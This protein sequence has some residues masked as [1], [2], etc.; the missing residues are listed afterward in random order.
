MN[1]RTLLTLTC[2]ISLAACGA[3]SQTGKPGPLGPRYDASEF[4]R[5]LK[6]DP[7]SMPGEYKKNFLELKRAIEQRKP[8][9]KHTRKVQIKDQDISATI[10]ADWETL[11]VGNKKVI[12]T[13]SLAGIEFADGVSCKPGAFR[14]QD[15]SEPYFQMVSIELNCE[16]FTDHKHQLISR[17]FYWNGAAEVNQPLLANGELNVPG[18]TQLL[19]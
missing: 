12:M 5:D 3:K 16:R 11:S 2:L 9:E 14:T 6:G 15:S 19:E 7:D 18:A 17:T 10:Q 4:Y 8:F 13:A 1:R